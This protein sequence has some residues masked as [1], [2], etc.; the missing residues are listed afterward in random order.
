MYHSAK[1]RKVFENVIFHRP[2]FN[3]DK[4]HLDK[5]PFSILVSQK[6]MLEHFSWNLNMSL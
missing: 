2:I 1:I 3:L 5:N 6:I 4:N